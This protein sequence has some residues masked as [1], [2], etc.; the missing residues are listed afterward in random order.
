MA[1]ER[2]KAGPA[3]KEWDKATMPL[4]AG[5]LKLRAAASN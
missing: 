4:K 3:M 1:D 2:A 5:K